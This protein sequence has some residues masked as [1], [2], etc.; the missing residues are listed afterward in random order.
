MALFGAGE[1]TILVNLGMEQIQ[2]E[3]IPPKKQEDIQTGPKSLY[4]EGLIGVAL[5]AEHTLVL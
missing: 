1:I 2:I 4:Q 3:L 5:I